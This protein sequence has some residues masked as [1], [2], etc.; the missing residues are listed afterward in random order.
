M[1][2]F[3]DTANIDDIRRASRL[4]VIDG[5]TTN[6]SLVAQEGVEYR[7]R[8]LEIAE[9]ID[10]PISAE[11]ISSTA[12]ELFEEGKRIAEWHENVVV[13]VA[14]S[15]EGLAATALLSAEGIK[16]NM[17]LIFSAN[18]ALLAA[19]AGSTYISPFLGRLDD[20]GQ[21]GMEIIE[22]AVQIFETFHLPAQVLAASIRSP[23][24]VTDAALAGAHVATIP[25]NVLFQMIQHPLTELG[26]QRF[27]ADAEQYSAV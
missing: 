24:H 26:I 14:M 20:A 16:V 12:D 21:R 4:G 18:Q 9:A 1:R 8:V 13:K 2:L 6:P 17:T 27:L 22:E 10:G 15:E 7:D 11:T 5:V 3:I 25:P 23:R 19:R